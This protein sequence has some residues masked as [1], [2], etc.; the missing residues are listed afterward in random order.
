MTIVVYGRGDRTC[1]ACR[2][3]KRYLDRHGIPYDF[4]NVDDDPVA[5][6][7]ARSL[8]ALE[9]PVVVVGETWWTG[10][11][12]SMLATLDVAEPVA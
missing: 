3:T 6:E 9:L 11:R 5:A 12:P 7:Y 1:Q 4:K 2:G 10:H 8:G